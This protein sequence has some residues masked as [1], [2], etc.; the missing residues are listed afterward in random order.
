[1]TD[2][3]QA[4]RTA[5][6]GFTNGILSDNALNLFDT[7]GYNINRRFGLSTPSYDGFVEDFPDA[8]AKMN[9]K[10]ACVTDWL[11]I[12]LLFQ[13]TSEE[14]QSALPLFEPTVRRQE[15]R[16]GHDQGHRV[17]APAPAGAAPPWVRQACG[18]CRTT[19]ET[20]I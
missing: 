10:Q 15:G 7:L 3:K 14:M 2:M 5:I 18:P 13:I 4:I 16:R 9:A 11:S 19:P 6:Q 1:M 20:P 8:A 17:A 12:E